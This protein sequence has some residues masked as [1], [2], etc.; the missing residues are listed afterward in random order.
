M[1]ITGQQREQEA[2]A[3]PYLKQTMAHAMITFSWFFSFIH[4]D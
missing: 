2:E 1:Y 4:T 3:A